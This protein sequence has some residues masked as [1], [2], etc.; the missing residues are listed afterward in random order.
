M[1]KTK[2]IILI[3]VALMAAA[4]LWLAFGQK[5]VVPRT[6]HQDEKAPI[7][8]SGDSGTV[9]NSIRSTTTASSHGPTLLP[10]SPE[11]KR[12]AIS[13]SVLAIKE[14]DGFLFHRIKVSA[15]QK[16]QLIELMAEYVYWQNRRKSML[17]SGTVAKDKAEQEFQNGIAAVMKQAGSMLSAADLNS[18]S[19]YME[20]RSSYQQASL[21]QNSLS[22]TVKMSDSQMVNLANVINTVDQSGV[23]PTTH[24]L[25]SPSGGGVTESQRQELL[26][27]FSQR[28]QTI[29]N[30]VRESLNDVQNLE[31]QRM[32]NEQAKIV[33]KYL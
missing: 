10:D 15:A 6:P 23:F 17:A 11:L 25:M 20:K 30:S 21:V 2:W 8:T 19:D 9:K 16:D 13:R 14:M 12:L 31:L 29:M 1:N 33:K 4:S 27:S 32:L 7:A 5:T 28:N 22:D 24:T 18:F 26:N 3:F